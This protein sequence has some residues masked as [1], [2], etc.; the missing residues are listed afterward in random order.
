[1]A[2]VYSEESSRLSEGLST[3]L[4]PEEFTIA[5]EQRV[6]AMGAEIITTEISSSSIT[7]QMG[8]APGLPGQGAEASASAPA[9][10]GDEEAEAAAYKPKVGPCMTGVWGVGWGVGCVWNGCDMG[11]CD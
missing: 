4:R 8:V 3:D 2:G 7:R 5:K 11:G 10:A 1:M 9:P 6:R